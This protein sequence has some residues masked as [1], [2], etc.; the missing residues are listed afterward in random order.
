MHR[1]DFVAAGGVGNNAIWA[2]D[3]VR[4]LG[5]TVEFGVALD[6]NANKDK[7]VEGKDGR[8]TTFI[9]AVTMSL[10]A[11][12]DDESNDL[13]GEIHMAAGVFDVVE[14]GGAGIKKRCRSSGAS[15]IDSEIERKLEFT[16]HGGNAANDIGAINGTAIPGVSRDHG[17]FDP[18]QRGATVRAGDSDGLVQIAE[19]A[20]D[21]DSF[22]IAPGSGME[23]DAEELTG[24]SEDAAKSTTS[25]DNDETT[26]ADLQ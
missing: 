15:S 9:D 23:A 17:S 20:F 4:E 24:R 18:N 21:A 12:F 3:L 14:N 10:T 26:H 8:W 1:H 6:L 2:A 22:M 11:I 5:D 13:T 7:V 25:V 19:E 16:A